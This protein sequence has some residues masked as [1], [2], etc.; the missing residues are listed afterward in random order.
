MS[1]M[2]QLP[3]TIYLQFHGKM[4][5]LNEPKGRKENANFVIQ[6]KGMD[7]SGFRTLEDCEKQFGW[8]EKRPNA[9]Q[10]YFSVVEK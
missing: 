6:Y 5:K 8:L 2:P 10:D 3:H 4:T 7:W 1:G 9:D